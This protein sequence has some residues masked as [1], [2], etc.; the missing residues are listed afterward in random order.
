LAVTKPELRRYEFKP[1][2]LWT[3]DAVTA[4]MTE[5]AEHAK[6]RRVLV[7]WERDKNYGALYW[8]GKLAPP[9]GPFTQIR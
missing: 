4:V 9:P 2:S 3:Q 7:V 1:L 5:V 6:D 8:H